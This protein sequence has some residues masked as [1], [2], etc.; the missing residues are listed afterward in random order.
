MSRCFRA[1]ATLLVIWLVPVPIRAAEGRSSRIEPVVTGA[2]NPRRIVAA[3]SLSQPETETGEIIHFWLTVENHS[4]EPIRNLRLQ[5]LDV[6]GFAV[7]HLAWHNQ[8]GAQHCYPP[9][10]SYSGV[11]RTD[12]TACAVL[13]DELD[14][15]ESLTLEG[16]LKALKA[17]DRQN[18][19]ALFEWKNLNNRV[20]QSAVS[21]GD[22][23]II[24]AFDELCP[25]RPRPISRR[26]I[27]REGAL[28]AVRS[29]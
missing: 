27:S 22:A 20:S 28:V 2:S 11:A 5:Q 13:S 10:N 6:P 23:V 9:A 26:C 1:L 15:E 12:L 16:E 3:G 17:H 18:L 21:L 29:L 25:G 19:T 14:P 7:R 4:A 24:S 8:Q